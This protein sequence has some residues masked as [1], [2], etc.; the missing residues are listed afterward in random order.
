MQLKI[1]FNSSVCVWCVL[2]H[3]CVWEKDLVIWEV[4]QVFID[5]PWQLVHHGL[6]QSHVLDLKASPEG[7]HLHTEEWASNG[8]KGHQL[9]ELSIKNS[10]A[11]ANTLVFGSTRQHTHRLNI[12]VVYEKQTFQRNTIAQWIQPDCPLL[13]IPWQQVTGYIYPHVHQSVTRRIRCSIQLLPCF[14]TIRLHSVTA[15]ISH[16]YLP[17]SKLANPLGEIPQTTEYIWVHTQQI[18]F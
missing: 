12:E 16:I 8:N 9:T 4:A 18:S 10:A 2:V 14:H 1:F 13:Y 15:M 6:C 11:L 3:M 5:I 17:P 7:S